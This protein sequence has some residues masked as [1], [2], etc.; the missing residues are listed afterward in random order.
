MQP[1]RDAARRHLREVA[2]EPVDQGVAPAAVDEAGSAQVTIELAAL[3]EVRQGE[4]LDDRRAEVGL[5]LRP[6]QFADE[7]LGDDEPAQP[8]RR[9]ERLAHAP[10]V[11]DALGRQS[12]H[13][14]HR[15]T[16][17]AVLR[18]VVVLEDEPA[19]AGPVEQRGAA[20]G[21]EN[22]ASGELVRRSGEHQ[23]DVLRDERVGAEALLVDR[24][25]PRLEA[26]GRE[27]GA[28]RTA[29][30]ILDAD[31]SPAAAHDRPPHEGHAL[32]HPRGHDHASR[33]AD[34]A[35]DPPEV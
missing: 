27:L 9:C 1:G 28:A 2:P 13:G 17:G 6:R 8:E 16:V 4:L 3:E 20:L 11:H 30:W 18:V 10:G 32:G 35:S 21:G 19:G 26:G 22:H 14:A 33:V 23:V 15:R 31:S 24:D 29:A 12:L 34:H 5:G 25:R 7:P